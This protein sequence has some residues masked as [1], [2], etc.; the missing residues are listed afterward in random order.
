MLVERIYKDEDN[1]D[2]NSDGRS[3]RPTQ[4]MNTIIIH[5]IFIHIK[6]KVVAMCMLHCP[7]SMRLYSYI[8]R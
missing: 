5:K 1:V 6:F 4:T 3:E 7:S 8:L 2:S